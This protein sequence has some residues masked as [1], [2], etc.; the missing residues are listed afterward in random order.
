MNYSENIKNGFPLLMM[1]Q[2]QSFFQSKIMKRKLKIVFIKIL[3]SVQA[4][5]G[6]LWAQAQTE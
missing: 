5:S 3:P 2:R 6:V 4:D 1:K